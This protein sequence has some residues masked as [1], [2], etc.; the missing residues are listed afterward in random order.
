MRTRPRSET[1]AAALAAALLVVLLPS[2]SVGAADDPDGAAG[3]Q[4]LLGD[5]PEP[6][7]GGRWIVVL[8][9]RSLADRVRD[10][11]GLASEEQQRAWTASATRAQEK[12][13][14][15]LASQGVPVN[16]ELVFV[17]TVNAFSASVDTRALAAL[18]ADREVAGVYPVRA[19]YP[20][21]VTQAGVAGALDP[22]GGRADLGIPGFDG[23]GVTVALL[24]TGVDIVHPFIRGRLLPGIDVLDPFSG[25]VAHQNPTLP[26]RPE[27]H[28]TE[29]AGLIVGNRG[30]DGLRGVAPAASLLPIRVAGWQPDSSGGVGVYART[31]QILAG[32]ELAVDPNADGD[33][34]DAVRIALVGLSEPFAAFADG[35]LARAA[36]GAAALGTLVVAPSGNDGLAGPTYGSIG[37][38]GGAEAALTVAATDSRPRSPSVHVFLRA[39]L[40]VLLSGEQPLAGTVVPG[41]TVTLP[42]VTVTA[43]QRAVVGGPAAFSRLFDKLGYS[44]VAGAAALLPTGTSSPEAVREAIAAGARAVLVD[45]ALPS[46]SLGTADPVDVPILGL[47]G[48][49]AT[50]TREALAA[51]IPV[52]LSVG[53]SSFGP[54]E[55]VSSI[56]PFSSSG[57][58]LAAAVK[59]ELLAPGVGL[60]TSDPGRSEGGAARYGTVSGSSAAAA[61]TAGSAALLAQA[62]PELTAAELKGA[63]VASSRPLVGVAGATSPRAVD[64]SAATS[65]ELVAEPAFLGLGAVTEAEQRL[66]RIVTVRNVSRRLLSVRLDPGPPGRG[67]AVIETKPTTARIRPGAALQVTVTATVPIVPRAPS[68][69]SGVLRARVAAGAVLRIPW[70]IAVPQRGK[71]VVAVAQLVPRKFEPSDL[72][73]AVVTIVAGRVD[74][75]RDRPQLLPLE[76]LEIELLRGDRRLGTLLLLRDV[77][78]G[79]YSFGITGRGPRGGRLARGEY[80]L[81]VVGAPVG[82]G[83]ETAATVRFT[84][85]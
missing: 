43:P 81:R 6:E 29:L 63:L 62:R 74:G 71:P 5:R 4:G 66:E 83:T 25:A 70:S 79:R 27:R 14:A 47:P 39:G 1:V 36:A 15:R 13:V 53:A 58:S 38:P 54:N 75:T 76:R 3:W 41:G 65:V 33:A 45:G 80:T 73:P 11:G 34:H 55:D 85:T 72:E 57:L 2:A 32:L 46:G 35:P 51:G 30:P 44:R 77:L 26:G 42:V 12:V 60:A 78:P 37:A 9:K 18:Q 19:A 20:S 17:R 24:D 84:I 40:G 23:T 61:L 16:P 52:Q 67:G 10:A 7:L 22:S 21:S 48:A 31:D 8:K 82:G 56:A 28:A 64:P 49:A 69:L 59:P 50:E 68:A